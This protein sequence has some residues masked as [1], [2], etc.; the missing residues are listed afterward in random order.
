MI[1]LIQNDARV[2]A[3]LVGEY[4]DR[5]QIPS[6]LLRLQDG[7]PLPP[8]DGLQGAIVLGGYM[9]VHQTAAYPYLEPLRVWLRQAVERELPLLGICLGA[10]LLA[11]ALGGE[12]SPNCR[13]E[14]G[15]HPVS[16]TPEGLSDPLF[17]GLPETFE[18][19]QWHQDSFAV[20]PGALHLA[21]SPVCPGQAF[22]F[23]SAYGVQFHPEADAEI[24]A[25]WSRLKGVDGAVLEAFRQAEARCREMAQ[26]LLEN[27]VALLARP[28]E[29]YM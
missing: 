24:V 23:G 13:G 11:R 8:P 21:S 22:R 27:F 5:Q 7:E 18:T 17:A 1:L 28:A 14:L 26:A 4:L 12:V 2:P 19:L 20:P 25:A 6:L 16:L 15:M 3:G 9:G 29:P 10:Q